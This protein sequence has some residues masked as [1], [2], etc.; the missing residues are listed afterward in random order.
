M[1]FEQQRHLFKDSDDGW[2][3]VFRWASCSSPAGDILEQSAPE[4]LELVIVVENLLEGR[5]EEVPEPL[6]VTPPFW[7]IE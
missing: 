5:G 2:Y 3:E 7:L 6:N 1:K 4:G